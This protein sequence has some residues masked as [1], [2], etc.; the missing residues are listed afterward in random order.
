MPYPSMTSL[1][2]NNDGTL[3]EMAGSGNDDALH[4]LLDRYE[5]VIKA[6]SGRYAKFGIDA[7]DLMQEGRLGLVSA[8]RSYHNERG[9]SFKTFA[10]LCIKRQITS[11]VRYALRGKN[12]P[13]HN[14]V[15][16]DD[17]EAQ[18]KISFSSVNPEDVV[19]SNEQID[20]VRKA[21]SV[22][23]NSYERRLINLYL[24]GCS[25]ETMAQQLHVSKKQV[26]NS[27]QRIKRRLIMIFN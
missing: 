14:Y 26:D 22:M 17:D 19:I 11:A 2:A 8:A 24:L 4:L 13:M 27:L 25:Y 18:N 7:D 1:M 16:L 9:A 15:S 12:L 20:A 3:A 6:Y 10:A 23:F 21:V 5:P